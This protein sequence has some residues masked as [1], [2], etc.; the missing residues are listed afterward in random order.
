V[1]AVERVLLKFEHIL[2]STAIRHLVVTRSTVDDPVGELEKILKNPDDAER[3]ALFQRLQGEEEAGLEKSIRKKE[4]EFGSRLGIS[5]SPRR[6]RLITKRAVDRR[7]DADAIAEE[8]LA[9]HRT[10]LDFEHAFSSRNEVRIHLT[11]EAI[12]CLIERTWEEGLDAGAFLKQS[13]QNYEHGLKLIK[14][15]T[16]KEE[17]FLPAEGVE[18]PENYLNRL[19]RETYKSE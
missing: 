17:F 11:E 12:D 16:G 15:K 7:A 13:F 8:V 19:I 9:I 18:N 3:E 5:F 1:S 4:A 14:E 6:I 2:P 10:A